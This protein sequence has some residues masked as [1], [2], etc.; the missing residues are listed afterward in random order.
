MVQAVDALVLS[1]GSAFGLA[2]AD[3]AMGALAAAGRG[4][5]VGPAR[6]PICPAAILFDLLNGGEKEFGEEA[7]YRRF[8]AEA[9]VAAAP[10]GQHPTT[11]G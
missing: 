4:H 10:G 8:G 9:V 1:G 2:A 5:A 7:P 3:G 6:V 11:R